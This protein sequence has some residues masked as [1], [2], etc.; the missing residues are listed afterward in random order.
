MF[1]TGDTEDAYNKIK[2]K[3]AIK[4]K[5]L[6]KSRKKVDQCAVLAL[7]AI[8]SVTAFATVVSEVI[9]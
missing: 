2:K 6:A 1:G 5:E 4:A 3:R 7:T 8:G 9:T